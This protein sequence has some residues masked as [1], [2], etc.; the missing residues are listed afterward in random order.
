M[1]AGPK[2]EAW[3][4]EPRVEADVDAAAAAKRAGS[5]KPARGVEALPGPEGGRLLELIW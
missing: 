1:S 4:Q 3:R 2:Q 5:A